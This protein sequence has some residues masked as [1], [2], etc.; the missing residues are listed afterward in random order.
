MTVLRRAGYVVEDCDSLIK[1]RA[2]LANVAAVDAVLM[3]DS[4]GV[5]P[6]EAVAAAQARSPL[7]VIFFRNANI[8]SEESGYD[9]VVPCLTPP[10][11]WLNDVE[12]L[13]ERSR[14]ESR[15]EAV[16]GESASAA[17]RIRIT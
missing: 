10:Q 2:V 8:A 4:D 13:I 3:C 16:F 14:A 9:L 5:S 15:A 12:A 1:L 17:F 7:P 6:R 11:V